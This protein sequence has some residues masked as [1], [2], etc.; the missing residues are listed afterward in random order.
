MTNVRI[1]QRKGVNAALT[2]EDIGV[3]TVFRDLE[4]EDALWMKTNRYNSA[5]KSAVCVDL[6]DGCIA[7]LKWTCPVRVCQSVTIEVTE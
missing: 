4:D 1:T 3:N 7:D 5:D 2:L 6:E